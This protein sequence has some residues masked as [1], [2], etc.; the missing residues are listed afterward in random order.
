MGAS[1]GAPNPANFPPAVSAA[2]GGS[3]AAWQRVCAAAEAAAERSGLSVNHAYSLLQVYQCPA[4]GARLVQ[5]R[6]PHGKK[7]G[8]GGSSSGGGGSSSG[9]VNGW[10]GAW[11]DASAAWRTAAPSTRAHCNPTLQASTGTFWMPLGDFVAAFHRL[12][13]ARVAQTMSAGDASACTRARLP[14]PHAAHGL[15]VLRLTPAATMYADC[16]VTDVSSTLVEGGSA[17]RYRRAGNEW[18]RR[19]LALLVVEELTRVQVLREGSGGGGGGGGGV[20]K[21]AG[22][23]AGGSSSAA[24][25]AAAGEL[26]EADDWGSERVAAYRAAL[27]ASASGMRL[28]AGPPRQVTAC[29]GLQCW[30]EAGRTYHML[31]LS[32]AGYGASCPPSAAIVELHYPASKGLRVEVVSPPTA[33]LARALL[34]RTLSLGKASA[35]GGGGGGGGGGRGEPAL[36]ASHCVSHTDGAG[37]LIAAVNTHAEQSFELTITVSCGSSG[38]GSGGSGRMVLARGGGRTVDC[39]PPLTAQLVNLVSPEIGAS[40]WGY[41]TQQ[42]VRMPAPV[43]ASQSPPAPPG[44]LHAPTPL[45]S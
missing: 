30:L 19:D 2:L 39:V 1:C 17:V 36:A 4:S 14:L 13:C 22:A 12:D 8:S 28:T 35:W 37:V 10:C 16:C 23:G 9:E 18:P 25:A 44:T 11:S 21:G 43:V 41:S 15:A 3:R 20:G 31:P 38:S 29:A 42:G 33:W 5:L 6:N 27:A 24:A 34:C 32:L 45:V 26:P 40:G 7:S